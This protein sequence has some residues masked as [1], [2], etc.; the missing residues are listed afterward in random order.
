MDPRE[1]EIRS[2]IVSNFLFGDER[3]IG[4]DD[5]FLEKGIIDSTGMLELLSFIEEKYQIKVEPEE[6]VPTNL[7]SISRVVAF[8]ARKQSASLAKEV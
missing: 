1:Q 7:D 5:S 3:P 8:I 4:S 2:F 6:L